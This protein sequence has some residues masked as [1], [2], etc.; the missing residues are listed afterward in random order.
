M[1]QQ[2]PI[3]APPRGEEIHFPEP[4]IIPLLNAFGLTLVILGITFHWVVV[5]LGALLFLVTLVRWIRDTA[6]E[7]DSLPLEHHH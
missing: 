7:I 1:S 3:A 2:E 4:S 5:A 6:H